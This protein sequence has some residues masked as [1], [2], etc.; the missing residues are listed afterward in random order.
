MRGPTSAAHPNPSPNHSIIRV[1]I[2]ETHHARLAPRFIRPRE[3]ERWASIV[4]SRCRAA[5]VAKTQASCPF[6]PPCRI[7]SGTRL[8]RSAFGASAPRFRLH[9]PRPL[10]PRHT[11]VDGALASEQ[12]SRRLC[13]SEGL[14]E[15][16]HQ[17]IPL[18]EPG[19]TPRPPSGSLSP[20]GPRSI[21]LHGFRSRPWAD[22]FVSK[23]DVNAGLIPSEDGFDVFIVWAV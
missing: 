13:D 14:S 16:G 19:S 10:L 4:S 5:S 15:E 1:Q 9:H 12:S 2:S 21:G 18:E 23:S 7:L 22:S 11:L 6:K 17:L 3:Y 8:G 20:Q